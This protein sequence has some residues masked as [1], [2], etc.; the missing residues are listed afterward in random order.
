M[1]RRGGSGGASR[2]ITSGSTF[3]TK[4]RRRGRP[5]TKL[6]ARLSL[7]QRDITRLAWHSSPCGRPRP[8]ADI[9]EVADR[10][11]DRVLV[12]FARFGETLSAG[13][14][15]AHLAAH[16]QHVPE[17]ALFSRLELADGPLYAH[18]FTNLIRPPKQ[19]VLAANE[20]ALARIRP[21][22]EALGF[23]GTLLASGS[24]T[25]VRAISRVGDRAAASVSVELHGALRRGLSM[26][27]AL[28]EVVSRD[29]LHRP[30]ICFGSGASA[31]TPTV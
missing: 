26:A 6:A 13:A 11:G 8:T 16:G 10:L 7:L 25:I 24:A 14:G 22:D 5:T 3:S 31:D 30:F 21:S 29:P 9:A 27:A 4:P 2:P 28:A 18:E 23:A 19:V 15:L 17:N 20:L 12:S 1:F